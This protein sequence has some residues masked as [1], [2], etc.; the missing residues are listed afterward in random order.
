MFVGSGAENLWRLTGFYG[1][2]RW[3]DKHKSWEILRELKYDMPWMIIGDMN[4]I[5]YSFEKE[6]GNV[7]G[8]YTAV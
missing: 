8:I 7:S 4:K 5:M 2:P 3:K 1:E 6:G